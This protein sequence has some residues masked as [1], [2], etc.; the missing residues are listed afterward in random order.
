MYIPLSSIQPCFLN[1]SAK[2]PWASPTAWSS[3]AHVLVP[4][5]LGASCGQHRA[6]Q[7]LLPLLSLLVLHR[8]CCLRPAQPLSN[9]QIQEQKKNHTFLSGGI[10]QRVMTSGR[11]RS[12]CCW[13]SYSHSAPAL[14]WGALS[15][16]LAPRPRAARSYSVVLVDAQLT[17]RGLRRGCYV[18]LLT[19][20]DNLETK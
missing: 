13:F 5:L 4:E 20:F 6:I 7:G 17:S 18:E 11:L 14:F 2:T 12:Q 9:G 16:A 1:T 15:I 8:T 3:G 19:F 10:K